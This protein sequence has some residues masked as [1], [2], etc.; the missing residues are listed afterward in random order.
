MNSAAKQS[1]S[2]TVALASIPAFRG[3][4]SELHTLAHIVNSIVYRDFGGAL[5]TGAQLAEDGTF[6]V[7]FDVAGADNDR[8][9]GLAGAINDAARQDFP[10]RA[11]EMDWDVGRRRFPACS[12]RNR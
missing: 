12:A 10:V 7:D 3:L 4:M 5:L 1:R 8:L 6:R 9:R 2:G 11:S